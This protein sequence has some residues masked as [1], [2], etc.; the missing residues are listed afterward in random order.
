MKMDWSSV[1]LDRCGTQC[2]KCQ[3]WCIRLENHE[4]LHRHWV[5]GKGKSFEY[6]DPQ[7]WKQSVAHQWTS[8]PR[9]FE[10]DVANLVKVL[11]QGREL[12]VF[13]DNF[14]FAF[15]SIA[16]ICGYQNSRI[17]WEFGETP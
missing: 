17:K 6:H 5:H 1:K 3:S 2:P 15:R 10:S 13:Q 7:R 8:K 4:S 11:R 12:H 14:D 16:H 9:N